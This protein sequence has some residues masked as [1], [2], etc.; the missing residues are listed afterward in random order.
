MSAH[1]QCNAADTNIAVAEQPLSDGLTLPCPFPGTNRRIWQHA[2]AALTSG[3]TRKQPSRRAALCSWTVPSSIPVGA[4]GGKSL[5][6]LLSAQI[7]TELAH[8]PTGPALDSPFWI[9][10]LTWHIGL[11]TTL[12]LG[13]IGYNGRKQGYW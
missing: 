12:L 2:Q 3:R 10:L 5:F 1:E 4:Y 6:G 11:F 9:Y 7:G 8:F 13:Q